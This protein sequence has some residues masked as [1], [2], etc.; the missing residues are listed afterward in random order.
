MCTLNVPELLSS[1]ESSCD[2]DSC[3]PAPTA[4]LVEKYAVNP[5]AWICDFTPAFQTMITN[6]NSGLVRPRKDDS[7]W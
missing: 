5:S 6:G 1:G 7:W 4:D 2:F 3:S